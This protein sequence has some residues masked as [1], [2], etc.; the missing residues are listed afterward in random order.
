MRRRILAATLCSFTVSLAFSSLARAE[1]QQRAAPAFS[2][3]HVKGAI[4]VTVDRNAAQSLTVRGDRRFIDNLVSEVVGGELRLSM[5]DDRMKTTTHGDQRV[6]VGL[7]ALRAFAAEGAGE[8][9]LNDVRGERFDVNYRGA[10]SLRISGEVKTF[11]M[12]AEGVGEVDAKALLAD[13]VDVNFR[14]VGDV[15]VFARNRLDA[16]VQGIGSLTYYGKPRTVK[17]SASG[18][19]SVDAGD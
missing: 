6:I 1:D 3:I 4:N 7:P 2:S 13:N 17:K 11:Q 8:I 5:R 12:K 19:G 18:L 10:G 16:N 15:R 9:R 14:G